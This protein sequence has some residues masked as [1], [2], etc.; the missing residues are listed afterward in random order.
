MYPK[1]NSFLPSCLPNCNNKEKYELLETI[2]A[3]ILSKKI[4][5]QYF[6]NL[7][8]YHFNI[9]YI[10]KGRE[11]LCWENEMLLCKATGPGIELK[12][13]G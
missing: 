1:V 11:T 7:T 6:L 8:L 4:L 2:L 9:C 12:A 3:R 10:S 5:V 13:T